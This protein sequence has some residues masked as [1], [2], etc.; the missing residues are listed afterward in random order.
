MNKS[1]PVLLFIFITKFWI[2]QTQ[3]PIGT[4]LNSQGECQCTTEGKYLDI[5]LAATLNALD[6][7]ISSYTSIIPDLYDF[8]EDQSGFFILYGPLGTDPLAGNMIKTNLLN[9]LR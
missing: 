9:P 5:D 7:D 8:Q 3:C 4:I 2:I 6:T 1:L